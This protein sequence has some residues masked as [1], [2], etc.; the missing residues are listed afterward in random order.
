MQ[1]PYHNP[2]IRMP[3]VEMIAIPNFSALAT[4]SF[5]TS[6]SVLKDFGIC[7]KFAKNRRC[8]KTRLKF[9]DKSM[10]L[11]RNVNFYIEGKMSIALQHPDRP[12]NIDYGYCNGE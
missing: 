12:V 4:V 1:L 6:E 11:F 7:G 3:K 9:A 10:Q 2:A 5:P 8:I